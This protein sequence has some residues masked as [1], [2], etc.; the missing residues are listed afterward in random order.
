MQGLGEG[1]DYVLAGTTDGSICRLQD[2]NQPLDPRW[3]LHNSNATRSTVRCMAAT[4]DHVVAGY[5]NG[6]INVMCMQFP[7]PQ[8]PTWSPYDP[9]DPLRIR[10]PILGEDLFGAVHNDGNK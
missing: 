4:E 9:R 3:V 8:L 6:C 10:P 2:T 5:D 7:P 1:P